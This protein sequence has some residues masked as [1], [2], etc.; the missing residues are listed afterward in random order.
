MRKNILFSFC[1]LLVV[2]AS[3]SI[4]S[5]AVSASERDIPVSYGIHIIAEES[6]MAMSGIKGNAIRFDADDFAR[7]MNLSKVTSITV[8]EVPS[9]AD[10]ELL[11]GSTVVGKGQTVS[12]SNISLMTY[13]ARSEYSSAASF[14]FKVEDSAYDVRC[15]LYLLDSE[16]RA[17][18]LSALPENSLNVSTHKN[19]TIYG[20]LPAYDPDGDETFI[21]VVSYPKSGILVMTDRQTGSY[22]YTPSANYTGKD[23]FTCVARDKYG[24]YSASCTVNLSVNKPS[25]SVVYD[26]MVSSP[27]YNAAISVTEAGIM[28]GERVG[29]GCYFYPEKTVSRAEFLVM[30]MNAIGI[31]DLSDGVETV[32]FDDD[33][34]PS[35]AS[36]YIAAA[37]ELGYIKGT[38]ENGNLCYLPGDPVSRAEAAV[39]VC[40]MI[41]AATPTIAPTFNDSDDIPV[42]AR[43][44]VSSLSYMGILTAKNGNI[45]ANDDLTRAEAAQLL[46]LMLSQK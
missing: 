24:N 3:A 38:Y 6:S 20:T 44:A 5:F 14:R 11:V 32:F 23:S 13:N 27:M 12:A 41:D 19:I 16:N 28:S 39:I 21:E 8:T 18:T 9:T 26:D 29:N 31:K 45:S 25:A 2:I 43:S 22:A 34:I 1:F 17:P 7:A 35:Y 4:A 42:F 46:E 15:D 36:G 30:A 37:Y 40:N 33:D 10:G